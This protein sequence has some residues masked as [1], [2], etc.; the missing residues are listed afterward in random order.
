MVDIDWD[1]VVTL[2]R[3]RSRRIRKNHKN[4]VLRL[5]LSMARYLHLAI[6][7]SNGCPMTATIGWVFNWLRACIMCLYIVNGPIKITPSFYMI[8]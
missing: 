7:A 2:T 5:E 4:R 3:G 6:C 8:G 1:R